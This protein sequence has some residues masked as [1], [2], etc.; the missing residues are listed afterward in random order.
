MSRQQYF[1][2]AKYFAMQAIMCVLLFGTIGLAALLDQHLRKSQVVQLSDPIADGSIFF[3][4]PVGWKMNKVSNDDG[5]LYTISEPD[6]TDSQRTISIRHL[7]I[8][9]QFLGPMQY[10]HHE[11]GDEPQVFPQ[12]SALVD[13]HNATAVRWQVVEIQDNQQQQSQGLAFCVIVPGSQVI[14]IVFQR[15]GELSTTDRIVMSEVLDSI[16]ISPGN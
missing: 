9:N 3:R 15:A 13:G 16:K 2:R 7:R 4:A 1:P 5:A 14:T 8:G 11:L 12:P 10:I 6:D